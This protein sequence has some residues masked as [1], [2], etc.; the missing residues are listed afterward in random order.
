MKII[1]LDEYFL[2]DYYGGH[3]C[4]LHQWPDTLIPNN[5]MLSIAQ[6]IVEGDTL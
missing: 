6:Y 1:V 2:N 4:V 3:V 5:Q